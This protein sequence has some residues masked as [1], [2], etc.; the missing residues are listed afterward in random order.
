M[1][2]R[3]WLVGLVVVALLA[4]AAALG[5][6]GVVASRDGWLQ[7]LRDLSFGG[8]DEFRQ[9][10]PAFHESYTVRAP[11]TVDVQIDDGDVRI[12]RGGV[13]ATVVVT[14]TARSS[15]AEGAAAAVA[16]I[17][18]MITYDGGVL[19]V[20]WH[21]DANPRPR[22]ADGRGV[23]VVIT[24]PPSVTT[25]LSVQ[26][27]SGDVAVNGVR[28][29]VTAATAFG[30]LNLV[31]LAGAVKATTSGGDI[32]ASGIEAGDAAVDLHT[33]FGDMR[34]GA[35]HAA[36]INAE[37][38]G[39]NISAIDTT[40]TGVGGI[41]VR[42]QFG[43]VELSGTSGDPTTVATDGG[44]VR[45]TARALPGALTATS[46]FGDVDVTL[47]HGAGAE[48]SVLTR[49]GSLIAPF[50][51]GNVEDRDHSKP[52]TGRIGAGGPRVTL[53]TDG[54]DARLFVAPATR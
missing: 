3:T 30:D 10:G 22:R 31:D 33:E 39:G 45:V 8:S 46:K 44:N 35:I 40:A 13:M 53:E 5:V 28:G 19:T 51:Q 43:D 12:A 41:V 26:T 21:G 2:L 11:L 6:A 37:T 32:V 36:S 14:P 9:N 24:I 29:S 49:F 42:T 4:T 25:T 17:Q 15:S 50:V 7:G 18:P 23:V 38:S 54:G 47:P 20:A 34:L 16:S 27:R 48:A 1:R 52:Q